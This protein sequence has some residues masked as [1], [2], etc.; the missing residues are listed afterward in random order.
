MVLEQYSH[1]GILLILAVI[2]PSI[3]LGASWALDRLKVRTKIPNV[4]KEETY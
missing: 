1:L 2:F 3:P 4:D